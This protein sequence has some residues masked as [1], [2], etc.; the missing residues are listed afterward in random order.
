[1]LSL[2]KLSF[3][4][5]L[6]T[7]VL[8][9]GWSA[10]IIYHKESA[11]PDTLGRPDAYMEDVVATVID[12]QGHP[13]LKMVASKMTHYL[14][15]DATEITKPLLTLYRKSPKPWQLTALHAKSQQG[16]S[17]IVL[18]EDVVIHHPGDG[19]NEKTTLLTP[20]LTVFPDKQ[21]ATT[22]DPVVI[23]QPNTEIHA[24]GMNADLAS[25]SVKLLSQARGEYSVQE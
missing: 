21:L 17:Q 9:S 15:N 23:I 2:K 3:C 22:T 6:P 4:G 1:M 16:L 11:L 13:T 5:L 20:T 8:L 10:F 18:W 14:H 12:K 19:Q 24:I 7:A 25:G